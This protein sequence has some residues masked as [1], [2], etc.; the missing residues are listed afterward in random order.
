MRYKSDNCQDSKLPHTAGWVWL[1][2]S[3]LFCGALAERVLGCPV[4]QPAIINHTVYRISKKNRCSTRC[5][6]RDHDTQES[7]CADEI[8]TLALR[9]MGRLMHPKS[10]NRG[11]YW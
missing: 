8:S 6:P 11:H 5:D 7:K 10:R 3:V 9:P 2:G 1:S 4:G